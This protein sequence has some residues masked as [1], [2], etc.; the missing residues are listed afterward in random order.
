MPTER[1]KAAYEQQLEQQ[2]LGA[3]RAEEAKQLRQ[4][5]E[6]LHQQRLRG[7]LLRQQQLQDRE[8]QLQRQAQQ[9]ERLHRNSLRFSSP[10]CCALLCSRFYVVSFVLLPWA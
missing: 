4:Q 5:Q 9:G 6:S 7:Q 3:R 10:S 1:Q 2:H 8:L